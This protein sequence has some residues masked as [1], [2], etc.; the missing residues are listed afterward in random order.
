MAAF[1]RIAVQAGAQT[2][3][4][5]YYTSEDVFRAETEQ[6]FYNS[7]V[8]IGRAEQIAQPGDYLLVQLIDESIMVVRGRD[9]VARAFFN[10]CLPPR[11]AHLHH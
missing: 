6:I 4:K 3:P 10:V 11:D 8:C 5:Q 1:L 7:W 2:L 9:G